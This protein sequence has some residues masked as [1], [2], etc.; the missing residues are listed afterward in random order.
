MKYIYNKISADEITDFL[1]YESGGNFEMKITN[2]TISAKVDQDKYFFSNTPMSKSAFIFYNMMKKD[3]AGEIREEPKGVR[4]FDFSGIQKG[5]VI[6]KCFCVDINSAYLQVLLNE[7]IISPATFEKI[8]TRTKKNERLKMDRLKSVGMFAS[9]PTLIKYQDGEPEEM[10]SQKNPLSWVFY[11]ACK[12]TTEIMQSVIDEN[13]LFYWVDGI[14]LKANPEKI[15]KKILNLGYPCKIEIIENLRVYE[16]NIIYSKD[17][18]EK[19]L[20]LPHE[21][22]QVKVDFSKAKKI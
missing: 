5:D 3:V 1:K 9:N 17:G 10:A 8:N 19:I 13:F 21:E 20:F 22:K 12:T 2:Y 6:E 11:Q 4:F 15:K 18:K 16:K 7:K 14:F